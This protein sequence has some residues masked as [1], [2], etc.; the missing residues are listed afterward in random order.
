MPRPWTL[1]HFLLVACRRSVSLDEWSTHALLLHHHRQTRKFSGKLKIRNLSLFCGYSC[2][3]LPI[4]TW[5]LF[6][7]EL[8]FWRIKFYKVGIG[9]NV[10]IL[11]FKNLVVMGTGTSLRRVFLLGFTF[12]FFVQSERDLESGN[13]QFQH[14]PVELHFIKS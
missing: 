5:L 7:K 1:F 11:Q 9:N 14:S 4:S 8:H 10:C 2:G 6:S 13:W 3:S 12:F